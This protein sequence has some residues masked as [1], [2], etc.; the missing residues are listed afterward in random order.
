MGVTVVVITAPGHPTL[1]RSGYVIRHVADYWRERGVR[2]E[3]TTNPALA[4]PGD[5]AWQHLD[6]TSV[7]PRYQALA[8]RYPVVINGGAS[9]VHKHGT[10]THLVAKNDSWAGPVIVKTDQNYGGRTEDWGYRWAPMRHPRFHALRDR[11][12]PRLTGRIDP[13][14]YPIYASP[15]GVPRWIWRDRRF[16][17]QRFLPERAGDS[18]AI[19]RWFFFG[20]CEYAYLA[21][22]PSP[23]VIGDDHPAWERLTDLP[24]GLRTLRAALGLDFGKIDYGEVRGELVVYDVNPAVS[25][26]GP[27]SSVLQREM[28]A[29]LIPGLAA[30]IDRGRR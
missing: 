10:A 20:D 15:A 8:A 6:V 4:P 21:R 25:A 5:I 24:E 19:R 18:Y 11:L 16:V 2:F 7:S 17:V 29:A 14:S 12:P 13:G 9:D 28:V 30:F 1:F 23:I 3:L 27:A 26:D 22:S